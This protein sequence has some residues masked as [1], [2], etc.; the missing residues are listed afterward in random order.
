VV[1]NYNRQEE[2]EGTQSMKKRILLSLFLLIPVLFS[3][4]PI[5]QV[6]AA[7]TLVYGNKNAHVRDLQSRLSSRGYFSAS[8]TGF[9]GSITTEAVRRFQR[10]YGLKPDGV[11]GPQTWA[12][13]KR[14]SAKKVSVNKKDIYILARLIHGEARGESFKGQV[15]VGAVVINRLH[16]PSF[17]DSITDVIFQPGAFTAVNDKQYFLKPNQT[18]YRAALAA[19]KGMDPTKNSLYYFNPDIATS[20]WIWTRPRTVKIGK[21]IFAR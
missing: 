3:M 5:P 4:G 2:R 18:A 10:D 7:P 21:H 13:L 17:P 15:A 11:A 8:V 16:S 20:K 19:V 6:E 9:Y 12:K 14:G 1:K